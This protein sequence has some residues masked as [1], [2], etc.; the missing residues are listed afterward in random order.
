MPSDNDD[1]CIRLF[2]LSFK[3]EQSN[4]SLIHHA[5]CYFHFVF[6]LS[7]FPLSHDNTGFWGFGGFGVLGFWGFSA[8]FK[9]FE[10]LLVFA[11]LR[12]I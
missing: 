1:A 7:R 10:F 5:D 12:I 4:S 9:F 8:Y 6:L 2:P 3:E 11:F